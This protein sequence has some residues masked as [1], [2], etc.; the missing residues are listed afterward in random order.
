MFVP[1]TA[2][3]NATKRFSWISKVSIVKTKEN[4]M[5]VKTNV[6]AGYGGWERY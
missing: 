5:K 4:T 2:A 6:R 1:V 3:G